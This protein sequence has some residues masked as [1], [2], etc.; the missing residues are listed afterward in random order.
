MEYT[1]RQQRSLTLLPFVGG[2]FFL[3]IIS[4]FVAQISV[5]MAMFLV[6]LIVGLLA[7]GGLIINLMPRVGKRK[8]H[9][10]R[11]LNQDE[12]DPEVQYTLT[13]DGEIAE[14]TTQKPK[15]HSK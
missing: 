9:G 13:D 8:S 6:I 14:T 1:L 2:A 11:E 12:F 15:R 10:T 7:L 5:G 4:A 3:A